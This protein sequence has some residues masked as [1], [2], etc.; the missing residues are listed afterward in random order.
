MSRDEV[1]KKSC[2]NCQPVMNEINLLE[3]ALIK[4]GSIA[5]GSNMKDFHKI[6]LLA[7]A[8]LQRQELCPAC[9][10]IGYNGMDTYHLDLQICKECQGSGVSQ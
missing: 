4:I 9:E 7:R 8:A 3:K 2:P 6:E 5:A 1:C 10:G